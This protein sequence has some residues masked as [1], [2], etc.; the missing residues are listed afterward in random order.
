MTRSEA[1]AGARAIA[2]AAVL[3]VGC[4]GSHPLP[5]NGGA[6]GSAGTASRARRARRADGCRGRPGGGRR[7]RTTGVAG[8]AGDT[9][10]GTPQARRASRALQARRAAARASARRG[11]V[12]AASRC[13]TNQVP[14]VAGHAQG[15]HALHGD[16]HGRDARRDRPRRRRA[17]G[18]SG[19]ACPPTTIRTTA[20][21][22]ST[23]GRAAAGTTSRTRARCSSSRRP[24]AAT[25]QAIYVALDIPTDMANQD[26][27]DNRDGPSSQ[28]W[29]AFELFHDGRRQHLLRRQRR[30]YVVRLQH[31]RLAREHV[32]LL[33]RGRRPAPLE[34]RARRRRAGHDRRAAPVRAAVPHP[35]PG[36][37]LGRRARRTTRRAT[38]P[39]PRSG[40]TT[41]STAT[42]TRATTTSRCRA[43]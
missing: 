6:S 8:A 32:G 5:A 4:G 13:R 26:C 37:D 17:R 10:D 11:A 38:D 42:P 24:R 15:L 35:R 39:S 23:S 18:R 14:T 1:R 29:E 2:L 27:Y 7:G 31:G 22:S 30:V 36:G 43:C 33:L 3:A 28:E 25:K 16:G 9:G 41:S 20:T 40:S 12:A 21:A 34:R 19:C